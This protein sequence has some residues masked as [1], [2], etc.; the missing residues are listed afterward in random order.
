MI[1]SG[2]FNQPK[3]PPDCTDF[4]GATYEPQHDKV[5]LTGQLLMVRDLLLDGKPRTRSEMN[6]ELGLNA[7][8]ATDARARDLRK[9]K[10]GSYNVQCER[11]GN[12]KDG[13]W[14]YRLVLEQGGGGS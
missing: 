3:D 14:E 13:I 12:P 10:H 5:R 7:N 6:Y 9:A 4:D 11:R 1:Q 8:A 2:L